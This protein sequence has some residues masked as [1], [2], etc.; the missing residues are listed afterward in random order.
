MGTGCFMVVAVGSVLAACPLAGAQWEQEAKLLPSGAAFDWEAGF[1]VGMD[2]GVAVLG[3]PHSSDVNWLNGS[4][5]V[6][7]EAESHWQQTAQLIADDAGAF[8]FLGWSVAISGGTLAAGAWNKDGATGAVYVFDNT[9]GTWSQSAK[10]MASDPV[11]N[12]GFGHSVALD[13]DRLLV[14]SPAGE[15]AYVFERSGGRWVQLQKLVSADSADRQQFGFSVALSGNWAVIGA[16][17]DGEHGL[18]SGAAYIF[19][20][21]EGLWDKVAKISPDDAAPG[22][23]FGLSV[24]LCGPVAV[25]G[26]RVGAPNDRPGAAYVFRELAGKWI[27]VAHLV[28][29]LSAPGDF[30]GC[31][32]DI[33]GNTALV[34]AYG[35]PAGGELSGAAY[36]FQDL[37]LG[38]VQCARLTAVDAAAGDC[39]GFSVSLRGYSA[40]VGAYLDDELWADSGSAYVLDEITCIADFNRDGVV[41]TLDV[42]AFLNAWNARELRAD[43]DRDGT[44]DTRDVLSFLNAWTAGC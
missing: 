35:D 27:Q 18:Q 10:L 16:N 1:D 3:V 25:I 9:A 6:F 42:L 28:P 39:Y 22:D 24:G 33:A 44:I 26:S 14:G 40:I 36:V 23:G 29:L 20:R 21:V 30:F 32:V 15:A 4:V 17:V 7:E 37:G 38:W 8:D 13:G 2:G 34:G 31:S 5:C 12:T 41:N 11:P 19:K 43:I